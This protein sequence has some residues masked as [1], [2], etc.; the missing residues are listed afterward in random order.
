[1]ITVDEEGAQT[2]LAMV[3][4]RLFKPAA[5]PLTDVVGLLALE[6]V[7]PPD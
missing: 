3:H 2:P 4:T 1:M 7:A 6:I 5:R